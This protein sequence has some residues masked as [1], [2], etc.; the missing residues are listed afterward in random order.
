MLPPSAPHRSLLLPNNMPPLLS[1]TCPSPP[2]RTPPHRPLCPHTAPLGKG[3]RWGKLGAPGGQPD[4]LK[5]FKYNS[6]E[7]YI[8]GLRTAKELGSI[9]DAKVNGFIVLY[10]YL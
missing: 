4:Y 1:I 8:L 6:I 3:D 5:N 7:L 2:L 10:L 9:G